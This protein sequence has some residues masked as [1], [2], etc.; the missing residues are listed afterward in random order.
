M[1]RGPSGWSFDVLR[2]IDRSFEYYKNE[3]KIDKI[4]KV[5]ID[6]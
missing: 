2:H 4:A 3:D 1:K 6:E 5:V